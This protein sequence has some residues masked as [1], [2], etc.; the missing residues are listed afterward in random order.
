MSI[1][2]FN[3][4]RYADPTAFEALSNIEQK[5]KRRYRPLVYICSPFSGEV[6][7]NIENARRYSRFAVNEGMIPLAPHLLFP[8]FLDDDNPDERK[9]GLFMGMVLLSKCAELWVFGDKVSK[10]MGIEI[11]KA[12]KKGQTIRYFSDACEEVKS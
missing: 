11:E 3:S 1:S 5:E 7:K 2:F 4:E 10:G 6:E 12:K 8:Q 9:L